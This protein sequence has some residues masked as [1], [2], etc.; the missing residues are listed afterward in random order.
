MLLDEATAALDTQSEQLV[1]QSL[2]KV[3]HGKT[4]ILVAHRLATV[5]N[6]DM[7]FVFK[8][9]HVVESGKHLELLAQEGLYS[10][11]VRFQLQ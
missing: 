7:I 4:A 8:D 5:M 2:E 11:L 10:D 6:A 1:Q 3:R 9:G